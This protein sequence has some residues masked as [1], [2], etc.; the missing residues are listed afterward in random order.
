MGKQPNK[1]GGAVH[2]GT[3]AEIDVE[4]GRASGR[5]RKM[6]DADGN[7]SV[8]F[9]QVFCD[10]SSIKIVRNNVTLSIS[11]SDLLVKNGSLVQNAA[12]ISLLDK[13]LSDQYCLTGTNFLVSSSGSAPKVSV[14]Y[15]VK[16]TTSCEI[17]ND[18]HDTCL[19]TF[20]AAISLVSGDISNSPVRIS[21]QAKQF[22]LITETVLAAA[23]NEIIYLYDLITGSMLQSIS[24]KRIICDMD[25]GWVL[26]T[27]VNHGVLA[28]FYPKE[29]Y[30]HVAFSTATLD[31]SK[32]YLGSKKLKS[33]SKL[34]CSLM[35]YSNG[36]FQSVTERF[37]MIN[38]TV[39]N[40][41]A[42]G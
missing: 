36:D 20:C 24:L 10:A 31:E 28:V 27:N 37:D 15:T 12:S 22:G 2:I 18:I 17:N 16:A 34:A 33:S 30:L 8:I 5:K 39:I 25:G 1:N 11:N 38:S 29:D 35:A 7:S 40:K 21:S 41:D 32:G 9:Y 4:Q 23:S 26:H 13:G 3:F 19:G 6:S 42:D 14:V